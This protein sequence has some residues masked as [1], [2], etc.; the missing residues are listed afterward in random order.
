MTAGGAAAKLLPEMMKEDSK[1]EKNTSP[2]LSE[3]DARC[4]AARYSDLKGASSLTHYATVGVPQGR[5]GTCAKSLTDYEAETYL[6][7]FPELAQKFGKEN[8][9]ALDGAR[10][11]YEE[12]GY[13]NLH[14]SSAMKGDSK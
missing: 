11:H 8:K 12:V 13:L 5:L 1:D 2:L 10:K 4:Y 3:N 7:S 14:Y 9:G 6:E